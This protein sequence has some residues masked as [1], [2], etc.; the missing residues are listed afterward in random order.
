MIMI[1]S[2]ALLRPYW[3]FILP[4]II[5]V[6]IIS[7]SKDTLLGDWSRVIDKH[8]LGAILKR[9]IINQSPFP[10]FWLY[11]SVGLIALGLSGPAINS[12]ENTHFRNLDVTLLIM[13]I[14]RIENLS[15]IVSAT[16]LLLSQNNARQIGL[17][18]FAGDAY[19]ASPFT[20]DTAALEALIFAVDDKT[21][22]EGGSRP[23]KA[24][25]L[26]RRLL[27]EAQIFS[28]DVILI[29]DGNSLNTYSYEQ[30]TALA[31]DGHKLHTLFISS[32]SDLNASAVKARTNMM[33]HAKAGNGIM[34]D[35]F[36]ANDISSDISRARINHILLDPR[37]GM[38]WFDYGRYLI[39]SA[40]FPF[41]LC[42][43]RSAL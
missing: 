19:L 16:Q 13:D 21:I 12:K 39:L 32:S 22:P 10:D 27:R 36:T 34:K 30:A 6:L 7:K 24:L 3:L 2:F 18:L 35:I 1:D 43:R 29:S 14:S 33:I 9:Q 38:E 28:G 17:I 25:S 23:E 11:L 15:N 20:D 42:F 5:L 40:L 37:N 26:A 8:L 31:K 4:I 41:L